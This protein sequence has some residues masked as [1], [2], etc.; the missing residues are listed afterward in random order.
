MYNHSCQFR[1]FPAGSGWNILELAQGGVECPSKIPGPILAHYDRS[2]PKTGPNSS[3]IMAYSR[4]NRMPPESFIL[5]C[6]LSSFNKFTQFMLSFI[7]GENQKI[8]NCRV[9]FNLNIGSMHFQYY[10]SILLSLFFQ[11]QIIL[12]V[13][14]F[15]IQFFQNRT[16][17]LT[18]TP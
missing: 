4:W 15:F 14:S 1:S 18:G 9:Q 16:P 6:L 2:R 11:F 3:P 5:L 10:F 13:F 12:L 8:V 17:E 7:H